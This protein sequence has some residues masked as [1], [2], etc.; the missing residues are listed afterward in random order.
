MH[1]DY[2]EHK[3]KVLIGSLTV[4]HA[5]GLQNQFRNCITQDTVYNQH[6]FIICSLLFSLILALLNDFMDDLL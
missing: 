2:R 1:C 5:L 6:N 3:K 4:K